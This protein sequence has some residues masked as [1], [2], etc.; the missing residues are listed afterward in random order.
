MLMHCRLLCHRVVTPS[1]ST[2]PLLS[3]KGSEI[4]LGCGYVPLKLVNSCPTEASIS[5]QL[6][7]LS[8]RF[9]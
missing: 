8:T 9:H 4:P 1:S 3:R 2:L 6:F 5:L 7:A